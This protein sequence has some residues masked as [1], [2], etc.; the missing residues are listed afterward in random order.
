MS[1][2][3]YFTAVAP[4]SKDLAKTRYILLAFYLAAKFTSW[5]R[6]QLDYILPNRSRWDKFVGKVNFRPF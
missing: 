5:M 6:L 2:E 1:I 3:S 4:V